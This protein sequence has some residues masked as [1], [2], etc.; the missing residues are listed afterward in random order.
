MSTGV[1]MIRTS[2]TPHWILDMLVDEAVRDD[3]RSVNGVPLRNLP[4]ISQ[5]AVDLGRREAAH[6]QAHQTSESP[7]R[8]R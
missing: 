6:M 2:E 3:L 1:H 5:W 8:D 4:A 7:Q